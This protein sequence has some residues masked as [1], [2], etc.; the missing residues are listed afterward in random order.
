MSTQLPDLTEQQLSS[1]T[2]HA[3]DFLKL[4]HDQVSTPDGQ[5]SSRYVVRHCGAVA[6]IPLFANG[7]I[8]LV[9][10][11]RYPV[12]QHCLEVPAGKLDIANEDK[13]VCAKRELAEETGYQA[14]R[15]EYLC[16]SFSSVG[17]S[18]EAIAMYVAYDI[19]AVAQ[20]PANDADEFTHP[21]RLSLQQF[22]QEFTAGNINEGRTQIALWWLLAQSTQPA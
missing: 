22:Q 21:V 16:D 17:Y 2:I 19:E 3:G 8:L 14:R 6:I 13:L 20:P 4:V 7:D 15:W 1:T 11:Y 12:G 18:D 5:Q 9:H 10:Q